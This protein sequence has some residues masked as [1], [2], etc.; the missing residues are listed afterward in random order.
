MLENVRTLRPPST[1]SPKSLR[2]GEA[3]GEPYR[4]RVDH[5]EKVKFFRFNIKRPNYG[6]LVSYNY[7]YPIV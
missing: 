3:T 5:V 1:L 6:N 7:Y 2:P 4:N